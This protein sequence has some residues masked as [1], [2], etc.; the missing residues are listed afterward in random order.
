M[1]FGQKIFFVKLNYLIS[2]VFYMHYFTYGQDQFFSATL[3]FA[4]GLGSE[5][6]G[7]CSLSGVFDT[8]QVLFIQK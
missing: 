2:R 8:M 1:D 3:G 7:H 6:Q 4:P 5:Q